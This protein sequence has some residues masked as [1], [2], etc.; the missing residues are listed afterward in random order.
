MLEAPAAFQT[1]WEE[2]KA[3][4]NHTQSP[5]PGAQL[6][7]GADIVMNNR[8]EQIKNDQRPNSSMKINKFLKV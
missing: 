8:D 1:A 5:T 6:A 2:R 3:G 7:S 4:K